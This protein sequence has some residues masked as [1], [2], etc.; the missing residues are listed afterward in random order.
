MNGLCYHFR[1]VF[2]SG[3]AS[4]RVALTF[5]ICGTARVDSFIYLCGGTVDQ[6]GRYSEKVVDQGVLE[7]FR[8]GVGIIFLPFLCCL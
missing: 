8:K 3:I 4:L 2:F 5:Q 7:S 6:Y 1:E